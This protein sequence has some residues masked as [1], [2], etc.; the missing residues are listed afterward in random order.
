MALKDGRFSRWSALK[1]KGGASPEENNAAQEA[2]ETKKPLP[3]TGGPETPQATD[4]LAYTGSFSVNPY[5]RPAAPVMAPLGGI[6]EDDDAFQAAPAAALAM[7]SGDIAHDQ[8]PVAY[9]M[10]AD[11]E[12][13]EEAEREL[14]PEETEVVA[15]LPAM[16][17][18]TE[19]SDFTPF[20]ADK[21]PEFIRRK[22]LRVLYQSHPILGFR[23]GLNDYDDDYNLIHT[24]IDAATQSSYVVGKGQAAA[25]EKEPEAPVEELQE[26][27][28][29]LQ[30]GVD[31]EDSTEPATAAHSDPEPAGDD[32][33]SA[34]SSQE[35]DDES[36][37]KI[38]TREAEPPSIS[39]RDV[40]KPEK[41]D[42]LL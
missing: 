16:E 15:G 10:P 22:A 8:S 27:D 12:A 23:D 3:A 2:A 32:A 18:L 36:A 21:V 38:A 31:D 37:P 20:M 33:N 11:A 40:R 24:L 9:A 30:A 17:T 7:V 1:S 19:K 42:K 41:R 4:E 6:E 28:A 34:S 13:D 5:R 25:M 14:S 39:I 29:P 26:S 35:T